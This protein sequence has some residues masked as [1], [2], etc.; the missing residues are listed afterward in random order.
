MTQLRQSSATAKIAAAYRARASE[1][2]DPVCMDEWARHLAG[3]EGRA[4]LGLGDARAPE[5]ELG[6]ALRTAWLDGEVRS[7]DGEQVVILGAGLDTRAARLAR[8]GL[9]FFEVD[10][11]ATQACKRKELSRIEDYPHDAAV[12]IPCDLERE[13]FRPPLRAGGFSPDR[14][15]L[16]LWEGVTAYLTEEA[17]RTTIHR[18]AS[19]LDATSR[20]YFDHLGPAPEDHVSLGAEDMGEPFRF[21]TDDARTLVREEGFAVVRSRAMRDLREE[22]RPD[23]EDAP[24]YARWFLVDA[25]RPQRSGVVSR[26]GYARRPR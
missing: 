20:L 13:D 1:R 7:F 24:L 21:L 6:I 17:V 9:R 23:A 16:V 5:M 4:L 8:P 11:P 2:A 22:R 19:T 14:P 12:M 3:E 26:G 18:I 10:H 15:A 25:A